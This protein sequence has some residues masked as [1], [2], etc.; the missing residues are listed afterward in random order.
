MPD[1]DVSQQL[2][3]LQ[4]RTKTLTAH[5]DKLLRDTGIAERKLEESVEKLKELGVDAS[6]LGSKELQALAEGFE[7]QLAEKVAELTGRVEEG[8]ALVA[9]YQAVQAG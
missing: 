6:G 7:A 9:K 4:A 8:E 2:A 1:Q 3:Q 5:R